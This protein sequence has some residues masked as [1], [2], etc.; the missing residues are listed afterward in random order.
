MYIPTLD[1]F[2]ENLISIA[3]MEARNVSTYLLGL[4][5]CKSSSIV[6]QVSAWFLV[7]NREYCLNVIKLK[8]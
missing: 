7:S 6:Y 2:I 3:E 5:K 1:L 4:V 8:F